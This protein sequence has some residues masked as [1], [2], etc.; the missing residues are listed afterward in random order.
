MAVYTYFCCGN[1]RVRFGHERTAINAAPVYV[2]AKFL[3]AP[4]GPG[5]GV[6]SAPNPSEVGGQNCAP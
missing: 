4:P 2:P 6:F 3:S 1:S 5:T